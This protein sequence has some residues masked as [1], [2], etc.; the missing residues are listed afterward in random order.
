[1]WFS[2][3]EYDKLERSIL[4][5]SRISVIRRGAEFVVVPTALETRGGRESIRARHPATGDTLLLHLD[6]IEAFEVLK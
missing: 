2:H 5:G 4:H 6:E 1:M 3:N